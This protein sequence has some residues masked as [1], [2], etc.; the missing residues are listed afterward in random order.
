MKTDITN[1]ICPC[2]FIKNQK[3]WTTRVFLGTISFLL[4]QWQYYDNT[5]IFFVFLE[6]TTVAVAYVMTCLIKY[7]STASQVLDIRVAWSPHALMI[8]LA[9]LM[10]FLMSLWTIVPQAKCM[11]NTSHH[12]RT[13]LLVARA[14]K[15][16]ICWIV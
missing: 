15:V 4:Q 14:A 2:C 5:I 9:Y 3:C 1:N 8:W 12:L 11:G 7:G 16:V 13:E 6:W 10:D